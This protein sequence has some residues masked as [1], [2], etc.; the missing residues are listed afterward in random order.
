MMQMNSFSG[1]QKNYFRDISLK[2]NEYIYIFFFADNFSSFCSNQICLE[3]DLYIISGPV[4]IDW[5]NNQ[6]RDADEYRP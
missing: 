4:T 6:W 3:I 1:F 5:F 2:K